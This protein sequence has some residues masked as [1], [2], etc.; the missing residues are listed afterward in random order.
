[1]DKVTG[2]VTTLRPRSPYMGRHSME[3]S[4]NQACLMYKIIG[5]MYTILKLPWKWRVQHLS[6][7]RGKPYDK[8]TNR[9]PRPRK[10]TNTTWLLSQSRQ[11]NLTEQRFM[12]REL[13]SLAADSNTAR[14]C[15][16]LSYRSSCGQ[17]EAS[18]N[19]V[20]AF[21]VGNTAP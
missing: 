10:L 15:S 19:Q 20:A 6:V 1:M 11:D 2:L 8:S 9:E 4:A 16:H 5:F 18:L 7:T 12:A 3:G 17:D 13:S 21:L 14:R